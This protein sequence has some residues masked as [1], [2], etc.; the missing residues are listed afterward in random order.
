MLLILKIKTKLR[1]QFEFDGNALPKT[2]GE[3]PRGAVVRDDCTHVACWMTN[4]KP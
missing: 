1:Q 4:V 3:A 2:S